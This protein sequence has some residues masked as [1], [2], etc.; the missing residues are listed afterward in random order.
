MQTIIAFVFNGVF[1]FFRREKRCVTI[2]PPT[3]TGPSSPVSV[4][5]QHRH[6]ASNKNKS[7]I[8]KI[9]LYVYLQRFIGSSRGFMGVCL[10]RKLK[11]YWRSRVRWTG[12]N[13]RSFLAYVRLRCKVVFMSF[14]PF[15]AGCFWFVTVSCTCSALCCA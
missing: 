12:K 5:H 11:G 2:Y 10:V 6:H 7:L 14:S 13:H 1:L 4:S 8:N 9:F 3:V 15:S